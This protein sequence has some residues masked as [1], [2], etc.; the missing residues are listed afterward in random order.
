MFP[1]AGTYYYERSPNVRFHIPFDL[2]ARHRREFNKFAEKRGQGKIAAHGPHRD[3]WVDCPENAINLWIAFGP[4]L[5]GNGLTVYAEDYRTPFAF[6]DGYVENGEKLHKPFNFD[7]A[8]GDAVLFH[9]N[10]LHG[11]EL[12]RTDRTR[13]VVSYRVTFGKPHYP[14]GHYH[15]YVH[16]GLAGGP[17][18]ALAGIPQNLQASFFRYQLRRLRYRITGTGRMTGA[19][20]AAVS[21]RPVETFTPDASIA[22]ADLPVGAIRPVARTVC[23]ARMKEDEVV[24]VSRYCPHSGGDLTGGW[25]DEGKIVCPLHCLPFD[26]ATGASP[27]ESLRALR[28]FPCEVRNGRVHVRVDGAG[29][30]QEEAV[31]E[32][33]EA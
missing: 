6:K 28:R 27:C 13:Y 25:I 23:V 30:P 15:H 8:P 4:V 1:D 17:F 32:M 33:Q 16:G 9:S 10:H 29:E 12:N 19:D 31:A 11:S 3:P 22:L 18:K 5:R 20:E 7:L 21:R 14:H 26:P 2:A 24:A